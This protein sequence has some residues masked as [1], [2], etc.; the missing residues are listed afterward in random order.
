MLWDIS[1]LFLSCGVLAIRT[2]VECACC[3][4][5]LDNHCSFRVESHRQPLPVNSNGSKLNK[6][7][8]FPLTMTKDVCFSLL[9]CGCNT[10]VK[11]STSEDIVRTKTLKRNPKHN[12]CFCCHFS[13]AELK[14]LFIMN[15]RTTSHKCGATVWPAMWH[16]QHRRSLLMAFW[17]H[18]H[19]LTRS[20]GPMCHLLPTLTCCKDLHTLPGSWK[21]PSFCIVDIITGDVTYSA[22]SGC[23][24]LAHRTMFQ[25]LSISSNFVQPL[26]TSWPTFH[27]LHYTARSTKELCCSV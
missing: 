22:W 3:F 18:R 6:E 11:M 14:D 4:Q 20:R 7:A 23:S 13:W 8:R 19:S 5:P 25:F 15:K 26:K 17:M 21:H 10:N 12:T 16:G 9:R 27:R 1:P 24:G 2:C